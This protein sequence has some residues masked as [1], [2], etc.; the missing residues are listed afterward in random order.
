MRLDVLTLEQCEQV[1]LW[2]NDALY[3]LRTP[4]PLTAEQ[5]ADFYRNVVCDRNAR[6]RYWAVLNGS[7]SHHVG[8]P[9]SDF[10]GMVGLENLE[11]ENEI[12]E[13]SIMVD[14][15]LRGKHKG[16]EALHLLLDEGFNQ[17]RLDLIWGICYECNPAMGFWENMIAK[18][19][20]QFHWKRR[21]KQ[22][23]GKKYRG[24]YFDIAKEE[25]DR[26]G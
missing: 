22:W 26:V 4:Y 2:R 16:G 8:D 20:M 14:P 21:Q 5:Q 10:I 12:A 18:Y 25:F 23:K 19:N 3:A 7:G 1:R 24:L 13:I 15:A 9:D 6:S 17:M 11:W